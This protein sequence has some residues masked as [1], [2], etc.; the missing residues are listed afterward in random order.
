MFS[1][2]SS[3][4]ESDSD[5]DASFTLKPGGDG[6]DDLQHAAFN[7]S[8]DQ[9]AF[10]KNQSDPWPS[11][12]PVPTVS[13][14]LDWHDPVWGMEARGVEIKESEKKGRGLFATRAIEENALV[15]SYTGEKMRGRE[16]GCT[17]VL[18]ACL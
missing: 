8:T 5:S 14:L 2:C 7:N 17:V 9:A 15:S 4:S 18:A 13:E 1:P 10:L 3:D 16:R 11:S 12:T 6:E